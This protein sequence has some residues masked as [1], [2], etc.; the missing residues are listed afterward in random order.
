MA[1][2]SAPIPGSELRRVHKNATEDGYALTTSGDIGLPPKCSK[3]L[4]KKYFDGGQLRHDEGDRPHDRERARD[5]ILY[6][7]NDGKLILEEYETIAIW[8]RSEIEGERI[9]KRIE[10]L[11]DPQAKE[12]IETFSASYRKTDASSEAH[13]GSIYSGRTPTWCRSHIRTWRS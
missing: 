11:D 2:G 1:G 5:V 12:L 9:H 3:N 4:Q 8:D 13:S 10:L 6:E 7:W